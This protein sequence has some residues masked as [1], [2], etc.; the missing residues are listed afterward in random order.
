MNCFKFFF[1]KLIPIA[2]YRREL[3]KKLKDNSKKS[4]LTANLYFPKM[5]KISSGKGYKKLNV[6]IVNDTRREDFH[7]GCY[8]VMNNL[9]FLCK[10]YN[11][12]IID[13]IQNIKQ[14]FNDDNYKKTIELSD[15]VII[16]GEGTLHDNYGEGIYKAAQV[17]KE[18][19]KKVFLINS[20]WQNNSDKKGMLD[21]F[22]LISVRESNSL[23]EVQNDGAK[24]AIL[25]PDLSLYTRESYDFKTKNINNN[26]IMFTDNVLR[27]K[28]A[29]YKKIADSMNVD[30]LYMQKHKD[31]IDSFKQLAKYDKIITGRFHVLCLSMVLGIPTIAE[32][33]NTHKV[34][35]VLKDS[36]LL[37]YSY[38]NYSNIEE[39]INKDCLDFINKSS[40]YVNNAIK[41]IDN[42]FKEIRRIVE[43]SS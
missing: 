26:K 23:S 36:G 37:D 33:S 40:V 4:V 32:E 8:T 24:D 7:L 16:N 3:R 12:N 2:K 43:K 5:K 30:M 28:T 31:Y 9:E 41:S 18:T 25:T 35:G 6:V 27:N 11:L 39:F 15:A 20:V 14:D 22:D 34:N 21:L 13:S 38:S 42:L 1:V 19:N 17:A 10:K 29:D